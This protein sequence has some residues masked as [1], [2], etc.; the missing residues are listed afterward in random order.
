MGSARGFFSYAKLGPK[1]PW[2]WVGWAL[3]SKT[4]EGSYSNV[5][6]RGICGPA[7]KCTDQR[8]KHMLVEYR[9]EALSGVTVMSSGRW[10]VYG[11]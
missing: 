8:T 4:T 11:G 9:N 7:S 10:E 6:G 3:T 2:P 1:V 5:H